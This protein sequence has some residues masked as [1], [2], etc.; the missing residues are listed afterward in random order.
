MFKTGEVEKSY[1][2]LTKKQREIIKILSENGE[3]A[4]REILDKMKEPSPARTLRHEL[5]ILKKQK[6]VS[7]RG[8]TNMRTWFLRKDQS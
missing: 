7:V 6:S 8:Q 2:H 5:L 4:A 3:L 1:A